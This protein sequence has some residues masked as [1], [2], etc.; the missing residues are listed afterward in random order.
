ML[1][2][3]LKSTASGSKPFADFPFNDQP[4]AEIRC[5]AFLRIDFFSLFRYDVSLR[6]KEKD[7]VP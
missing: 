4:R 1:P 3:T 5:G 2:P 7:N 6:E